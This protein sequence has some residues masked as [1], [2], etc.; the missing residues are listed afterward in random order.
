M[1]YWPF[2]VMLA[3]A[4]MFAGFAAGLFGIGGG[5]IIVPVLYF[6]LRAIG[7]E[8]TAMHVAVA[9]SLAT[10]I[11]TSVRS[12][13]AHNAKGA[14]DWRVLRTWTPWIVLGALIGSA[15][16]GYISTDGLTIFFGVVGSLLA[17]QIWFGGSGWSLA[18]DLPGGALRA[19]LGAVMGTISSLMGIGGGTLGVSLMTLCG[20]PMHQSVATAAGFGVAIGLP[21]AIAAV[22]VGWGREGLPPLSL[23]HV[24]LP[25]LVL[26][27][28]FTVGM[29]PVGAKV[30]HALDAKLL[31]RLFAPLLL[32][33]SIR[34]IW[35]AIS[36]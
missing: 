20:R 10:I 9:T 27:S 2:L 33:V 12:V 22:I 14:V 17:A 24:N 30:A 8:E 1:H 5:A 23:G 36:G 21:G 29:A 18:K 35:T 34:M 4:A 25:A 16:A 31:R 6:L 32:V 26:I 28:I 15:S 3:G 11:A 13:L 19:V 7:F